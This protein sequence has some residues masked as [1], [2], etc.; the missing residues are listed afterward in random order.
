MIF[1]CYGKR[2][3]ICIR[4]LLIKVTFLFLLQMKEIVRMK[5]ENQRYLRHHRS[6]NS[7]NGKSGNRSSPLNGGPFEILTTVLLSNL[8]SLQSFNILH[9]LKY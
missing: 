1:P 7:L 5:L 4:G 3:I 8:F 9:R 6:D 2:L